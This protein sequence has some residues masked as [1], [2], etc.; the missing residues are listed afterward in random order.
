MILVLASARLLSV[1]SFAMVV[2]AGVGA[3]VTMLVVTVDVALRLFGAGIPGTLE[4]VT[5]YLMSMVVFLPLARVERLEQTIGVDVFSSMLPARAQS[6]LALFVSLLCAATYGTIGYLTWFD[7]MTKYGAGTYILTDRFPL[8]IWPAYFVV[9][10]AFGLAMLVCLLRAIELATRRYRPRG[11]E[12]VED[13]GA[14][15]SLPT[16]PGGRPR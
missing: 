5:Y 6:W 14:H 1:V 10:F 13:M 8:P 3:A 16:E 4:L 12:T 11:G 2:L 7:A 15:F 9:P